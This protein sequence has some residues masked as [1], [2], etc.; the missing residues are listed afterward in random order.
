MK[1]G[2]RQMY[3]SVPSDG[4]AS[5]PPTAADGPAPRRDEPA[6]PGPAAS[7][8]IT[9]GP[10]TVRAAYRPGTT[11]LQAA[12]AAGFRAPASCEAGSCGTCIARVV[13]GRAA[14]RN[15]EVLADDEV[16]E[17]WVLTCQAVPTSEHTSVVYE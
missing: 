2:S 4:P 10:R 7:L 3:D 6:A 5:A 8:T 12:R 14:M 16:A 15:N 9:L 11:V 17:G 13:E 1:E